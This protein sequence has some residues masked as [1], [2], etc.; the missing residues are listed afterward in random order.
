VILIIWPKYLAE[1][2]AIL[3]SKYSCYCW[4]TKKDYISLHTSIFSA[5][6]YSA[7]LPRV[8]ALIFK[9]LPKY[10]AELLSILSQHIAVSTNKNVVRLH[11][12][13]KLP[14]SQNWH[15]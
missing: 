4:V 3:L 13:K 10:L 14:T 2:L 15:L 9:L 7:T 11:S 1:I 12:K 8:H 5:N 6:R